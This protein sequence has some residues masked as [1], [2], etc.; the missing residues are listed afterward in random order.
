MGISVLPAEADSPL[1]VDPNAVLSCAASRE[2]LQTVPGRDAQL[3]QSLGRI[4]EE[5]LAVGSSL[6]IRWQLAPPHP[7]KDPPRFRVSEGPNHG[8]ERNA[9]QS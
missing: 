4:Q 1:V 7:F 2:A 8:S 3:P 9:I 5:E 6:H